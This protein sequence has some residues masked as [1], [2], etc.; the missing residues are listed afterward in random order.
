MEGKSMKNNMNNRPVIGI[1]A[2]PTLTGKISIYGKYYID[3]AYVK[4]V[5]S[6]GARVVPLRFDLPRD[7][8]RSYFDQLNGILF[9]GGGVDLVEK[10][11]DLTP[12]MKSQQ[13]LVNWAIEAY[14]KNGDY[15]PMWGTCLGFQ[16]LAIA[17]AN[18][19]SVMQSGF[20]SENMAIPLD[21]T[22]PESKII[23]STRLFNP[24]EVD[25]VQMRDIVYL[26]GNKNV[27]FN[28]HHDGIPIDRWISNSNLNKQVRL[29]S[30]N[31][32]RNGRKY[33]SLLEHSK[34][35]IYGSQF[36]PEKSMFEWNPNEVINHSLE[37]VKVNSYFG[38][39]FIN[40]CRKNSHTFKSEQFLEKSLIYQFTPVY[41][42][43]LVND[44]EQCYFV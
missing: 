34:Y 43:P 18:D 21:F 10:N 27:T 14:E 8:M 2:Q 38:K 36:H 20:D 42:Y 6:S 29:I 23:E 37:S 40:E 44:F 31:L 13:M 17:L 24:K 16:G 41:T 22:M 25:S 33:A 35:P 11:G 39:F 30:T 15:M 32:D 19:S 5:E 1:L 9:A 28:A 26:L 4:F 12:Y 7:E 3:A